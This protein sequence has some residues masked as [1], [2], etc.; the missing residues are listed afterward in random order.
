MRK[1]MVK[2]VA[3]HVG[4]GSL[5]VQKGIHIASTAPLESTRATPV[6]EVVAGVTMV[7]FKINRVN[8]LASSAP[9]VRELHTGGVNRVKNV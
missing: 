3:K 8:N 9:P 6:L 7:V 2:K 4:R 1:N 5:Q